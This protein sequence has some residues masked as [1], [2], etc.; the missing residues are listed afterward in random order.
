MFE[1]LVDLGK[2][3]YSPYSKFRVATIIVMK[4][5]KE[6]KGVNV[7]NAAYGSSICAERSAIVAAISLGYRKGDFKE[8]HCLCLDSNKI[9]TS[10]FGCRQV[11]SEFFDKSAPIYFYSK[12]GEVEKYMVSE[13]CP[14][15][16]NENDLK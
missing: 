9:S 10:C 3:S 11:I 1:K 4:D 14:Y 7:E 2:N 13:L 16:F 15:P 6:I 12:T 8:L 5:G